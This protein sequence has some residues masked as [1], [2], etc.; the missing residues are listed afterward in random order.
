MKTLD[1]LSR[2]LLLTGQ[3]RAAAI[4]L[5]VAYFTMNLMRKVNGVALKILSA[6]ST[7]CK[8]TMCFVILPQANEKEQTGMFECGLTVSQGVPAGV[9]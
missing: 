7:K 5:A 4:S 2:A 3:R 8:A 9:R 6:V 1:F